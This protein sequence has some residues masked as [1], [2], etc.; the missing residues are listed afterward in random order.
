[1]TWNTV[2]HWS[3]FCFLGPF[4]PLKKLQVIWI[5]RLILDAMCYNFIFTVLSCRIYF[6]RCDIYTNFHIIDYMHCCSSGN[7]SVILLVICAQSPD[8]RL[9]HG[10]VQVTWSDSRSGG[11]RSGV[12]EQASQ[13]NHRPGKRRTPAAAVP[14]GH[15]PD[16]S[17]T[18]SPRMGTGSHRR[19]R[20][21][22]HQSQHQINKLVRPQAA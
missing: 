22:L 3:K 6:C 20:H 15:Q 16:G 19:G 10:A 2:V 12:S 8:K 11:G 5:Q 17:G 13:R 18:S 21:L 4:K 7:N 14:H 1:M 9:A